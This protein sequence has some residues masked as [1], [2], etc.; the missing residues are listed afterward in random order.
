ML[1]KDIFFKKGLNEV[2]WTPMPVDWK[3]QHS[4]QVISPQAKVNYNSVAI[5]IPVRSFCRYTQ[6]SS[7]L[8]LKV[9][10]TGVA[11]TIFREQNKTGGITVLSRHIIQQ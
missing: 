10:G 7:K 8:L 9:R 3:T 6:D 11:T 5:I 2:L 1:M 4:T